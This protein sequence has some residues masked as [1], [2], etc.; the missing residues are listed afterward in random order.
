M[1]KITITGE[2]ASG[3]TTIALLIQEAL[4][5]AGFGVHNADLDVEYGTHYPDLQPKRVEALVERD[6]LIDIETVQVRKRVG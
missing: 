3:K 2:T 6:T 4:M 5:K 1:L